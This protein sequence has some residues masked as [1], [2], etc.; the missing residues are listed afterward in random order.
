MFEKQAETPT[1]GKRAARNLSA[2]R[3]KK[4][5]IETKK[6]IFFAECVVEDQ[7][8]SSFIDLSGRGAIPRTALIQ[9]S[10]KLDGRGEICFT[11]HR[12]QQTKLVLGQVA[13][14]ELKQDALGVE[15]PN[16]ICNV[17]ATVFHKDEEGCRLGGDAGSG[18]R[19]SACAFRCDHCH[20]EAPS[21][22]RFQCDGCREFA[23]SVCSSSCSD[24][25]WKFCK[26]CSGSVGL[27]EMTCGG[28]ICCE[29]DYDHDIRCGACSTKWC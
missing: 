27:V 8:R 20:R 17:C 25:G 6:A 14:C 23:C 9:V 24:C 16:G 11:A 2:G 12:E 18:D 7:Q 5:R 13:E 19:C 3:T 10:S 21:T 15:S 29:C 22:Y 1:N 4:L 26:A 28:K